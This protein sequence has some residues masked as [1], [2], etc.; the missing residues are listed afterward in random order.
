MGHLY[1]ETSAGVRHNPAK[2]SVMESCNR[3]LISICTVSNSLFFRHSICESYIFKWPK[4]ST[5]LSCLLSNKMSMVCAIW[6]ESI[7]QLHLNVSLVIGEL[8]E[9]I[10]IIILMF[11]NK[12]TVT[13]C[14][15]LLSYIVSLFSA[16]Y[17]CG[18]I[19]QML[20]FVLRCFNNA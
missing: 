4:K 9:N 12:S 13:K 6:T 14:T 7:C 10:F 17:P 3:N 19:I 18:I 2:V 11:T 5:L 1:H 20:N 8:H 16:F 15:L